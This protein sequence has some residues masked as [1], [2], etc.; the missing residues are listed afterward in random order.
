MG[1][2]KLSTFERLTQGKMNRKQRKEF[3]RKLYSDDPGLEVVHRHVAGIDVGNESHFVAVSPGKDPQSV[4]EFGS[5]TAD[6]QRMVEWLRQHGVEHV[7]MQSTG[8]YWIAVYDVL[9]Q[10]GFK[11]CLSNAR[12]TKNLPGRKSDVQESQWLLKLHTYGLLRNS[13]RPTEQ[14]RQLRTVWRLRDRNV[15]EAARTIQHMQKALT[16]M[17][18]QLA[19]TISDISG[20]TGQAIIRS[21]LKGERNP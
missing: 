6:L 12:D 13:F 1:K 15:Q 7:V 3:A 2:R 5:W 11:V 18:I 14:I 9:E 8:V 21:I 19:N 20:L 10:A 17:N 4:Q 16:T